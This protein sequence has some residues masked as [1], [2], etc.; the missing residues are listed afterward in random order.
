[1][2]DLDF[3]LLIGT[4]DLGLGAEPVLFIFYILYDNDIV[5]RQEFCEACAEMLQ[6]EGWTGYQTVK[7]AWEGIPVDCRD[8]IDSE[9]IP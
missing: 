6:A 8:S 5:S 9:L 1:M 4:P 7:A 3:T 2:H